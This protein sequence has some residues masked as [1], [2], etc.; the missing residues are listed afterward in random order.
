[1]ITL[2]DS[3]RE[4]RRLSRR[5]GTTY[6]WS[7][8]GLPRLKR[9]HVWALYG[10]CRWADDIVDVGDRTVADRRR[11]LDAFTRRFMRDWERG[12]SDHPVLKAVVHTVRAFDHDPDT[13]SRFIR[14]MSMDLTVSTYDT[15]DD[16]LGYMDGSAAVIGEMMLPILE[17]VSPEAIGPARDLGLAF[18]LT[19]F[20]R[21]V[22]EDLDRG[23]IYLPL[24]DLDQFGVDPKTR[25]ADARWRALMEFEITRCRAL[26]E[27]ADRGIE[28]LPPA[29]G[30]CVRAARELYSG[31]LD[32]IVDNEY[33]VFHGR[34]RVPDHRKVTTAVR[35]AVRSTR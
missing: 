18:Q 8:Y 4:C 25:I 35:L 15:W 7:T 23:R 12:H 29:E 3:Y 33:D 34:L 13:F 27:S 11:E 10:F 17:P 26:Y 24:E 21:D 16:L 31:I 32:R 30:R 22:A 9:H 14:S 19:N 6:H 28:L 2:T 20:L 1:M 5:H